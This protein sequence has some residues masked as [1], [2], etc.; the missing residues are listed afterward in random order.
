MLLTLLLA[1]PTNEPTKEE[2]NLCGT[3]VRPAGVTDEAS[4]SVLAVLDGETAC[5]GGDTGGSGW[6]GDEV[7]SPVPDGNFFEAEVPVGTYG[8]EVIAGDYSGCTAAE[9]T[10]PETCSADITVELE[11]TIFVD[12][13]NVYLYPP[14]P[15]EIQVQIPAWRKITAADPAYPVEGWRVTAWPDGLLDTDA[16]ERD[17]L[18]YELAFPPQRFQRDAGWCVRGNVAQATIEDAMADMGFLPNEIADFSE[19]WD[20]GFPKAR[21]MTV[22]PQLDD[23]SRLNIQPEPEHLLRAWFLVTEGC[24]RVQAPELPAVERSGYHAAEWGVAF[25]APLDRPEVIVDGWR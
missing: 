17:F 18:F 19:A 5:S 20:G 12:K 10:G 2:S 15:T 1:C 21:W 8:V 11:E 14:S 6:W 7:A 23:L 3:I 9:V 24:A 4:V 13:P 22:Y 16:G 25:L